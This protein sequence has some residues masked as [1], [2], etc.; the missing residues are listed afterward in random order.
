MTELFGIPV[1]KLLVVLL[2]ALAVAVGI[3]GALA[4]RHPVLVKLGVRN[5]GRRK[6]RTALIVVGLMLGTTIIAT[7]LTTGDTMSHTTR[8]TAIAALGHTDELVSVKGAEVD[9]RTDLGATTGVEYFDESVVERI[10]DR[11]AATDL[12]DGVT[13]AIVEQVGVQAPAQRQTEPRVTLFAAE[14][15][16]MAGFGT[17]EGRDGPVS[18][19]DL[20]TSQAFLNEDAAEE[21]GVQTG[22][23]VLVFAG[24]P[25]LRVTV[26]DI[27]GYDGAGTDG[28]AVLLRSRRRRPYSVARGKPGTSSSRTAATSSP[29]QR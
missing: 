25:P 26:R 28:G 11:L 9:L 27:V 19:A 15:A 14:P 4:I 21:L 16:R 17:I 22:D 20:E 2:V 13:P 3:L 8:A 5:V 10:E 18:L 23:R 29:G 12:V 1:D 7:A 24:G 6:G